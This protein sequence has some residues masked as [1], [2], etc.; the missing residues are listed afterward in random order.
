MGLDRIFAENLRELAAG[1]KKCFQVLP[2]DS[3]CIKIK[4]AD[5]ARLSHIEIAGGNVQLSNCPVEGDYYVLNLASSARFSQFVL[6]DSYL[7]SCEK[8]TYII[9]K[10]KVEEG[11]GEFEDRVEVSSDTTDVSSANSPTFTGERIATIIKAFM[12]GLIICP[13]D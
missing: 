2:P 1:D 11:E 8:K 4:I 13:K 6:S 3:K 7:E 9:G 10:R 12:P 5:A